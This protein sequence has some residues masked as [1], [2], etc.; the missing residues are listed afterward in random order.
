MRK[1][2]ALTYLFGFP[3]ALG[4]VLPGIMALILYGSSGVFA[5]YIPAAFTALFATTTVF[6]YFVSG[7]FP[8]P[9][10]SNFI[11]GL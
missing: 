3:V 4:Q 6:G 11:M 8:T 1:L 5:T 7:F 9:G 10:I 2:L